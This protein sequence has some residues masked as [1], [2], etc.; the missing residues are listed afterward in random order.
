V[1]NSVV[2]GAVVGAAVGAAVVIFLAVSLAVPQLRKKIFPYR[3]RAAEPASDR[4]A[5]P[6]E[7]PNDA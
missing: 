7:P 3:G 4:T 1:N 5:T 2:A 6:M